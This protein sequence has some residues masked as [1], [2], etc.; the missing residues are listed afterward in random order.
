MEFLANNWFEI[1]TALSMM[2]AGASVLAK[3]TPTP[4]DDAFFAKIKKFLDMIA[5]N[6]KR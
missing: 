6:P 3:F 4:K 2:V 1:I 5:L